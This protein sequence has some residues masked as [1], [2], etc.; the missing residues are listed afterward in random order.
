[1]HITLLMQLA[2]MKCLKQRSSREVSNRI[3]DRSVLYKRPS[4]LIIGAVKWLT[5]KTG[6]EEVES[7]AFEVRAMKL[8]VLVLDVLEGRAGYPELF[9][10]SLRSWLVDSVIERPHDCILH[11]LEFPGST[12]VYNNLDSTCLKIVKR[13]WVSVSEQVEKLFGHHR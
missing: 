1:M 7:L 4:E 11:Q 8:E 2:Y 12:S 6:L 9:Q 10:V 5:Q 13:D 3:L